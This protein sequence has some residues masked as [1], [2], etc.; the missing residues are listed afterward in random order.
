M[1]RTAFLAPMNRFA[2][3]G[4]WLPALVA[5][6]LFASCAP[7][8]AIAGPPFETDDPEPVDCHHVEVD[9]AQARQSEP[10]A[11]GP[12]WEV[13]YGPTKNVE[14]SVGGQPHEF[15]VGSAIRFIP[16]SKYRPQVGILPAVSIHDGGGAE[17]FLPI[18]A[19]KTIGEWTIFGGG[20]VSHGSEFTGLSAA[21]NFR[22]GSSLGV[23]FYHE[24]QHNPIVPAPAR[25]G[26][27]YVGQVGPSSAIMLWI[28][29]ALEPRGTN[30]LY[31]GFQTIIS[32]AK[33]SSNCG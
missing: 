28:G 14:L 20:G 17:T 30:L 31:V 12:V 25:I 8:A 27:G 21:R 4:S 32:P 1:D 10:V 7:G 18:W 26:L 15:E 11:T 3:V 13:D 33:R 9:I 6:V 16:E 23:E 19:Q 2:V 29:R 22:S 24:S 5:I